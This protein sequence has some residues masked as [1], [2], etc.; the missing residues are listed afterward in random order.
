[1]EEGARGRRGVPHAAAGLGSWPGGGEDGV[2]GEEPLG[3]LLSLF[4]V[5]R[6]RYESEEGMVWKGRD[7][8]ARSGYDG[9]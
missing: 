5:F 3:C 4:I 7:E 1:M 8:E 9:I 6:A 2:L